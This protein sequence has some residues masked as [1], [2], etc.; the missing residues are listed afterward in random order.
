MTQVALIFGITEQDGSYLS[1]ILLEKNY[2]VWGVIRHNSNTQ[3]IEHIKKRVQL[4]YGDVINYSSINNVV[5]EI[6]NINPEILE[7]Y[8]LASQSHAKVSFDMPYYT[9][10]VVVLGT[11]N[12]LE[13]IRN[14]VLKD[15]IRFQQASTSELYGKVQN[16]PQTEATP[17]YPQSPYSI[18]TL[19]SYWIVKNYREAYNLYACNSILYSHTSPRRPENFI[20]K[21]ITSGAKRTMY[22][23]SFVLNLGNLEAK[24]DIGYAKE[25]CYGMWLMLQQ[26]NSSD[27]IL[28]TGNV[29]TTRELVEKTFKFIGVKIEWKGTGILEKGYDKQ[30]GRLLVQINPKYFRPLDGNVLVGDPM[31]A[32]IILNWKANYSIDDLIKLMLEN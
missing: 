13:S 27:Y 7:I 18:A 14:S 30:T 3:H 15:K 10:Q 4:R 8:N 2:E 29:Y 25:Y 24:R 17:F 9:T 32:E 6:E 20:L 16:I 22:D 26:S 23:N 1:E 31:K 11:L 5:K 28:C 21:K 12:I 19:Y